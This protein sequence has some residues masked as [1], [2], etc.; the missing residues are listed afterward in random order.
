LGENPSEKKRPPFPFLRKEV[1]KAGTH[2]VALAASLEEEEIVRARER[3][4][5][6]WGGNKNLT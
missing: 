1:V 2:N 3:N 6:S 4:P 5:Y